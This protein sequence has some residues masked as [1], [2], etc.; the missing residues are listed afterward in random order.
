MLNFSNMQIFWPVLGGALCPLN[1]FCAS[2]MTHPNHWLTTPLIAIVDAIKAKFV[3]TMQ[4]LQFYLIH[5][6]PNFA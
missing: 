5:F 2:P 6:F 3:V 1:S 4:P